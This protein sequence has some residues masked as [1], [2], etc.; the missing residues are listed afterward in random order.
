ME[1]ILLKVM[2]DVVGLEL[3]IAAV[4]TVVALNI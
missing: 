2:T 4:A 1:I 3:T